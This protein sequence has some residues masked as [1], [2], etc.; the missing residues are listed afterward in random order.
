[1]IAREAGRDARDPEKVCVGRGEEEVMMVMMV[2][3]DDDDDDDT[4]KPEA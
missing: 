2:I 4:V 1:M 3:Y